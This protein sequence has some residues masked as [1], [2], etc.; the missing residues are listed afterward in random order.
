MERLATV[1]LVGGLG[2]FALAGVASGV[3]PIAHLSKIPYQKLEQMV[4]R[5]SPEFVDLSRRYPDSFKSAFGEPTTESYVAALRLGRATYIAEAC[6]HCHSQFVRHISNEDIRFEF[7]S[8][9]MFVLGGDPA[10]GTR[11]V[12]KSSLFRLRRPS[13]DR[14]QVDPNRR[15]VR[16]AGRRVSRAYRR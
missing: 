15:L 16:I 7:T 3:L 10:A 8:I 11:N 13:S 2:C 9:F 6:W 5:P 12:R 4:S 14:L 1:T